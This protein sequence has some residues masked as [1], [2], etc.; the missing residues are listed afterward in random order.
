M[1]SPPK[2]GQPGDCAVLS[3]GFALQTD[4]D[5]VLQDRHQYKLPHVKVANR[6]EC[7]EMPAFERPREVFQPFAFRKA[8]QLWHS[9][10]RC[11]DWCQGHQLDVPRGAGLQS[12]QLRA[13]GAALCCRGAA[14]CRH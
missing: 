11:P 6:S 4:V 8:G 2:A 5:A 12:C 3:W 1:H 14:G 7:V 9:S 13:W 10:A